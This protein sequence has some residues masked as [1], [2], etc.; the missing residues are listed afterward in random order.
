M[1]IIACQCR[2]GFY[3]AWVAANAPKN[4]IDYCR[5]QATK[6]GYVLVNTTLDEAIL[7]CSACQCGKSATQQFLFKDEA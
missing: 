3:V 4:E 1:D 5:E 7:K 6:M 2:C